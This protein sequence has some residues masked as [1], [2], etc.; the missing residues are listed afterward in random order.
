[1]SQ[2]VDKCASLFQGSLYVSGELDRETS[3]QYDLVIQ[4]VDSA[5]RSGT[6]QV[7]KTQNLIE[8]RR[9]SFDWSLIV[10]T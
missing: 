10:T 3:A 5:E 9:I 7:N 8:V 1:M 4:V 6:A 2:G